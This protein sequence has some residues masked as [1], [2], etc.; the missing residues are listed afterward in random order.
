VLA[1]LSLQPQRHQ[2]LMSQI[3]PMIALTMI[4]ARRQPLQQHQPHQ[5]HSLHL[6]LPSGRHLYSPQ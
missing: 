1:L 3:A 6:R 2:L 4:S 5:S